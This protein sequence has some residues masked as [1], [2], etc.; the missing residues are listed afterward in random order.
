MSESLK[1]R[2]AEFKN[3][4]N[5]LPEAEETPRTT[6]QI[7]GR[8]RIEQDWQRLLFYF[9]SPDEAHG[10]ESALL[11]HLMTALSEREGLDFAFSRFDLDNTHVELEVVT[12][13][14]RRPDAVFWSSEDWF[15]CWEL[16][17]TAAE[18]TD[19][20][21]DYVAADSF[22][23]IDLH[24]DNVPCSG[25]RYL[26]LAP[27]GSPPPK[28]D[29]FHQVSWEW[30]SSELQS[31]LSKS[32]GRYPAQ[33]TAQLNDFIS[34]IQTELTMTEYRENQQEKANLYFDYYD[35]IKEA[36]AAFDKQW[37]AFAEDWAVQLAQL[38]DESG[39]G[40][41]STNSDNDVI[42]TFDGNRDQWIF[43][44]GYP[45]WAGITKE[46]W[47][48]NKADLSPISPT[49]EADDQ[50][51]L[52]FYHRLRQ[53][54]ERAIRDDTLEFQLWHGTSSTDEFEYAFRDALA[55]KVDGLTRGCPQAVT[56]TGK[57]GNPLI[58][59]YDIPVEEYDDFFQAYL[60]ALQDGLLDLAVEH[61]ELIDAIDQSFEENLQIF[62]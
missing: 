14:G 36:Q 40:E 20:T 28:A 35:E 31:F 8:S 45:D 27:E 42:L 34:T 2:L 54:R 17:V 10:L 23:S 46:R 62:E 49:A 55:K 53:N 30:V 61:S 9:L 37:D 44:Q 41:T 52:A 58:A 12:S 4:L 56:L 39:T 1:Q 6:L 11:E 7:L 19:Q 18:G 29:E 38:F 57:R 60:A 26:Y 16:K 59:T 3:R 32:H 22:P 51:R 25:H 5:R 24:K 15:L 50:I 13:N 47:W 33:T 43:R 21:P 48:R